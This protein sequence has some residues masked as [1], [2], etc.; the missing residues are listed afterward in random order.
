MPLRDGVAAVH[1]V[2]EAELVLSLADKVLAVAE[3]RVFLAEIKALAEIFGGPAGRLLR[4]SVS[5]S[6]TSS[7]VIFISSCSPSERPYLSLR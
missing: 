3:E 6:L 4:V 7:L 2:L 5:S 1:D